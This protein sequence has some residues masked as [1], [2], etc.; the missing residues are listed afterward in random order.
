MCFKFD[1]SFAS[2]RN[3]AD[4]ANEWRMEKKTATRKQRK[5]PAEVKLNR[6]SRL[7][8]IHQKGHI[9]IHAR[10][11][12]R[13]FVLKT[14]EIKNEWKIWLAAQQPVWL[15]NLAILSMRKANFPLIYIGINVSLIYF[16]YICRLCLDMRL[17][18]SHCI[19]RIGFEFLFKNHCNSSITSAK[20]SR[21]QNE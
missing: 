17:T 2:C 11:N 9:H 14:N 10:T 3:E 15:F 19:S 6:Q 13:T 21:C 12:K 5:K 18:F 7:S 4:K 1:R 8:K 20:C 16:F